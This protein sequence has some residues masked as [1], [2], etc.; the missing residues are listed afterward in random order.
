VELCPELDG[1]GRGTWGDSQRAFTEL[2][3]EGIRA[4]RTGVERVHKV[5]N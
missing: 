5:Q 3:R 4:R 1:A 2:G